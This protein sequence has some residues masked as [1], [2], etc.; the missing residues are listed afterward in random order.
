MLLDAPQFKPQEV[1][2]IFAS[3]INT[4]GASTAPSP[5]PAEPE[6]QAQPQAPAPAAFK[7]H[8]KD[9]KAARREKSAM[10]QASKAAQAASAGSANDRA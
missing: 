2:G 3:A 1:E 9:W 5:K 7:P 6:A 10:K 8:Y 4:C